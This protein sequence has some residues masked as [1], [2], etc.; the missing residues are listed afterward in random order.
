MI[1]TGTVIGGFEIYGV[2]GEYCVAKSTSPKIANTFIVYKIDSM[3]IAHADKYFK[4]QADA[5]KEFARHAFE[6]FK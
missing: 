4:N 6:W 2:C 1:G 5:E 3:N